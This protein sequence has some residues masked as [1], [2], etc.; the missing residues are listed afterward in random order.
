[1]G[2][3]WSGILLPNDSRAGVSAAPEPQSVILGDAERP[4][5]T[6]WLAKVATPGT[7]L[8]GELLG[9]GL[10]VWGPARLTM[11]SRCWQQSVHER[12]TRHP[13]PKA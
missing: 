6:Q 12:L 5:A 7:A 9:F 3:V 4:C 8:P 10:R 13:K 11:R 2:I 1:M